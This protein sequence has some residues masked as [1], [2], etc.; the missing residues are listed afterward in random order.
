MK[1]RILFVAGVYGVGKT[2]LCDILS[3][4]YLIS[5]YSSSELISKCNHE[6]YGKNKY[7]TNSN[8]NQE[9]LVNQVNKIKDE[10]FILNGH[11]CL[12]EKNNK[13]IVLENEVFKKLNLSCILL[14]SASVEI[15][16]ENLFK[17]DKIYYD[18]EY[19]KLLLKCEEEQA[20]KVSNLYNIPLLKYNMQFNNN[21]AKNV[22]ELLKYIGGE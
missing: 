18:E 5:S 14:L 3:E 12:K 4:K 2:T 20:E 19:I 8:R 13:V 17:R 9:I 21:D 7:V 6:E 15:I 16:K 10:S 22:I 11:F 1:K